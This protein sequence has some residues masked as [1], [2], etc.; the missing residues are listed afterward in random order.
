MANWVKNTV[1]L[2]V[3]GVWVTV[4]LTSLFRGS[5]PDPVTWGIPGGVYFAL[6]PSLP[7]KKAKETPPTSTEAQIQ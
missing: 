7:G 2:V 1:M 4:V 5:A 3:L 6:N